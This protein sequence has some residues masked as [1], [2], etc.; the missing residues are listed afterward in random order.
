M[1]Y[2]N[3]NPNLNNIR[4][5]SDFNSTRRNILQWRSKIY[6]KEKSPNHRDYMDFDFC[7]NCLLYTF[8]NLYLFANE[9]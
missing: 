9:F 3:T 4:L 8:N 5:R 7:S 1:G 2:V 6:F